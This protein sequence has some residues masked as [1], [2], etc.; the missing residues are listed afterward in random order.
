MNNPIEFR[1]TTYT[2]KD[3]NLVHRQAQITSECLA[4]CHGEVPI[5]HDLTTDIYFWLFILG[6]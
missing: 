3:A 6:C 4:V 2:N 5:K 1:G